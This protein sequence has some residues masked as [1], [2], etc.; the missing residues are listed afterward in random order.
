MS[1]NYRIKMTGNKTRSYV[2]RRD[3]KVTFISG[4]ESPLELSH[5]MHTAAAEVRFAL[6]DAQDGLVATE[7][8]RK[9]LADLYDEDQRPAVELLSNG[10][11]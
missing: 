6:E 11:P 1:I 4:T 2:I 10:N 3:G 5:V 9:A 8:L 7:F